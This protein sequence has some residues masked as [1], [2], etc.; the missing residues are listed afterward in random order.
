MHKKADAL[1]KEIRDL[2]QALNA[3]LNNP[4]ASLDEIMALSVYIDKLI[5]EYHKLIDK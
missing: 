4:D 2:Q 1:K 5:L 3:A